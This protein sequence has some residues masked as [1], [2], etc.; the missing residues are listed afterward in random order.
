MLNAEPHEIALVESATV[1][2][3]AAFHA[4]RFKPGDRLITGRSEYVSNAINLLLARDPWPGV[5]FVD[6]VQVP[7]DEP[8]LGV[9]EEVPDPR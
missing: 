1:A 5:D 9:R 8:G 3:N 4:M 7:A 2:W 6:G